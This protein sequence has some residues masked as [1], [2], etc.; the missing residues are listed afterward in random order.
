MITPFTIDLMNDKSALQQLVNKM[1]YD[2]Q[3]ANIKL[4]V[5]A[6]EAKKLTSDAIQTNFRLAHYAL[7]LKT[8]ADALQFYAG[9][10]PNDDVGSWILRMNEDQGDKAQAV[11]ETLNTLGILNSP[12]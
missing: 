2:L 9:E 5:V 7:V 1:E 8:C 11:L 6:E 12:E 3:Q 10:F 4:R